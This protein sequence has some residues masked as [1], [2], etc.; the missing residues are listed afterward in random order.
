MM[1]PL[2][3]MPD[4]EAR[5]FVAAYPLAQLGSM[6]RD[7]RRRMFTEASGEALDEL[8]TVFAGAANAF[9]AEYVQSEDQR[10]TPCQEKA[11]GDRLAE[12]IKGQRPNESPCAECLAEIE[13]LNNMTP[14][15]VMAEAK[16]IAQRIVSRA[17][18][19]AS[20]PIDRLISQYLPSIPTAVVSGW[21][22][23]AVASAQHVTGQASEAGQ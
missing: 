18:T 15:Q 19:N 14:E 22:M 21:I 23:E 10:C 20:S 12:I 9:I 16:E 13:R 4:E 3:M 8:Q 11:I 6:S 7:G 2:G 17:A 5:A 1:T